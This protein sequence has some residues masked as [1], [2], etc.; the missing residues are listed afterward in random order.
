MA[1]KV[2]IVG[3]AGYPEDFRA[4]IIP[5]LHRIPRPGDVDQSVISTEAGE[6]MCV[7]SDAVRDL[8]TGEPV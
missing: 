2:K 3:L 6:L 4:V 8:T 7:P 1:Q 5:G